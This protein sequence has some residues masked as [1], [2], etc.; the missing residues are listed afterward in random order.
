MA[1]LAKIIRPGQSEKGRFDLPT[2]RLEFERSTLKNNSDGGWDW[3]PLPSVIH[4]CEILTVNFNSG[5][6]RVRYNHED[7]GKVTTVDVDATP[8]FNEYKLEKE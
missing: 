4:V 6:M 7:T 1:E 5:T 8:F 3:I 2:I